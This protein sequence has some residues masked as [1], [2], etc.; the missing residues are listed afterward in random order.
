[1]NEAAPGSGL[2][3]FAR[4]KVTQFPGP[5]AARARGPKPLNS[6]S[7]SSCVYG[8]FSYHGSYPL[9]GRVREWVIVKVAQRNFYCLARTILARAKNAW[10]TEK[11][12]SVLSKGPKMS[13]LHCVHFQV[14]FHAIVNTGLHYMSMICKHHLQHLLHIIRWLQVSKLSKAGVYG[15][16]VLNLNKNVSNGLSRTLMR[17]YRNQTSPIFTPNYPNF[18]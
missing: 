16:C 8:V 4:S 18:H 12:M 2:N 15:Y 6:M 1:M 17:T 9:C 11:G 5:T 3:S 14:N 7:R 13:H 10:V